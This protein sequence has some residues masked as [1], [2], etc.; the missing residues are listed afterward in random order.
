MTVHGESSLAS[1]GDARGA[2][3]K[4][5]LVSGKIAY[6]GGAYSYDCTIR[7]VSASG[8]RI[9]I[10]GATV[11]PKEFFLLD[12]KRRVA[13][14]AEVVWRNATQAGVKF[15]AAHDLPSINEPH[16]RF[17]RTLYIESCLR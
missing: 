1:G 17:L 11:L 15:Y 5:M 3:R 14:D 2:S 12:L 9:G 8:A 16:L 7:D 4:R 13:F 10:R 6:G